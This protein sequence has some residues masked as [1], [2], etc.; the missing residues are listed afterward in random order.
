MRKILGVVGG[1]GPEATAYFYE[2]II[3]HTDA[4]RDQDHIDMVILSHASMPDRTEAIKS[5]N[6]DAF[7]SSMKGEIEKL[8]K[9]GAANIAIPCNTSHF[10][11]DRI[12]DM[13]DIPVINMIEET[14]RSIAGGEIKVKKV[15]ILATDG[16]IKTGLYQKALEKEGLEYEIPDEEHQKLVMSL[17]YDDIKAGKLGDEDKFHAAVDH[18]HE[19]GCNVI[20]LACTELSVYKKHHKI[21]SH[22]V[23]SLDVLVRESIVRSGA[24]YKES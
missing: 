20:I 7:L 4:G 5:G 24:V 10:F 13:T 6:Y 8:E 17:I 21:P 22:C 3:A 19:K 12:K 2:E 23:D 15:G 1:M 11:M 18:L 16:S 9:C 14:A